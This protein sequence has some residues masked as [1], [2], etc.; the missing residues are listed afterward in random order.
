MKSK[1][2]GAFETVL[3]MIIK[4]FMWIAAVALILT[5]LSGV[6]VVENDEVAVILRFG[7]IVESG[8]EQVIKPGLHFTFPYMIDE[9]IKVPVGKVQE[10]TIITHYDSQERVVENSREQKNRGDSPLIGGYVFTGDQNIVRIKVR[11]KY[12]ISDA[13]SYAL[14]VKDPAK[15]IDGAVSGELNSI[16]TSMCVDSIL[17]SGKAQLA[18]T[19]KAN[20]QSALSALDCGILITNV[21]FTDLEPPIETKAAFEEVNAASV[22]KETLI[23]EANQFKATAIPEAQAQAGAL[24]QGASVNQVEAVSKARAQV[25]EFEGLYKQ[26][27]KNPNM[28]MDSVFRLRIGKVLAKMGMSAVLPQDGEPP[29]LLL[30]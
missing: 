1:N 2:Y 27:E 26:Y 17:T 11:V 8:K 29:R 24:V 14:H 18:E 5:L 23:Q 19:L 10:Q 9:V 16:V 12:K 20:A 28:I 25:A 13:V 6:V 4:Y 22:R 7:K 21:E 3:N 30:P 15:M